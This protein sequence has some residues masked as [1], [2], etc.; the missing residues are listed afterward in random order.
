MCIRP[1]LLV[2][3]LALAGVAQ[4]QQRFDYEP[5]EAVLQN[6]QPAFAVYRELK[7]GDLV[8]ENGEAKRAEV[9]RIDWREWSLKLSYEQAGEAPGVVRYDAIYKAGAIR[10]TTFMASRWGVPLAGGWV[11]WCEGSEPERCAR[12]I[13]DLLFYRMVR[14][15]RIREADRQFAAALEKYR[16]RSLRPPLPE[17]VRKYR[18][19]AEFALDQ[20]KLDEAIALYT[21]GVVA[22]RWWADGYYNL[23]LLLAEQKY[24]AEAVRIMRRFIALEEGS[25]DARRALDLTYRWESLIPASE[26]E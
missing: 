12:A 15:D 25:S 4:A 16:D 22:A 21:K 5:T 7:H 26:R 13:A 3:G 8:L 24:Y 9:R 1:L 2:L 19:Q 17:E 10:D 20:K 11:M 6:L 14:T 18:I 23:A